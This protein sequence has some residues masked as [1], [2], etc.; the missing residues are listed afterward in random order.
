M[1]TWMLLILA[2]IGVP[3]SSDA[4][5][6]S[7]G[8][9]SLAKGW[10]D[11]RHGIAIDEEIRTVWV[12]HVGVMMEPCPAWKGPCFT[13]DFLTLAIPSPATESTSWR[14]GDIEVRQIGDPFALRTLGLQV[15]VVSY[16][17]F[18]RGRFVNGYLL[19]DDR[20]VIAITLPDHADPEYSV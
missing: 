12:G 15:N 5:A 20:G 6:R 18:L 16:H 2:F 4:S 10:P 3:H 13:S 14:A 19:S 9:T 1:R 7:H 11:V 17:V 8:Y